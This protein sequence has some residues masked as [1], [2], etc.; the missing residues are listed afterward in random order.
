MPPR[1][2]VPQAMQ[3]SGRARRPDNIQVPVTVGCEAKEQAAEPSLVLP[4]RNGA[5]QPKWTMMT[6][7]RMRGSVTEQPGHA[8]GKTNARLWRSCGC[9]D[10]RE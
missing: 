1:E 3:A 2:H 7:V 9:F 8:T 10:E 4:P 6:D 5:Q